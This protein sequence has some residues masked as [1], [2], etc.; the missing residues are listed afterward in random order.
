MDGSTAR[1][2]RG[3]AANKGVMFRI[4]K[5]G[6]GFE[7]LHEFGMSAGDGETPPAAFTAVGDGSFL[8]VTEAGGNGNGTVFRFD[9]VDVRMRIGL[10]PITAELQWP[11]SSTVDTLELTSGV[12]GFDWQQSGSAVTRVGDEN[13]AAVPRSTTGQFFRVHR[14]WP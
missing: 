6:D 8:G 11:A 2:C 5:D 13:R 1:R 10:T 3:G 9:P 12:G 4:G 7:V 14:A